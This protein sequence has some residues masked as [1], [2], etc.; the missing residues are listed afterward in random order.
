[1]SSEAEPDEPTGIPPVVAVVVTCDSGPWLEETLGA[2]GRQDYPDL[3]VLVLDAG[4]GEDPTPRVATALPTAFIR[5]LEVNAGFGPSANE[6]L[7]VVE[8]AS[9]YLFCHDD[10]APEPQ[11]V[12]LMVEEAY[13]S[14]A[15][16]VAPKLVA[17][18]DPMRLLAVG[19]HIDKA[20]VPEEQV[21][22]GELDQEQYDAVRDV[23]V[24]PG[25]C[26]LVRADLFTTLGGFDPEITMFGEDLDLCWR[27]QVLGARV[28]VAPA[29]RVRHLEAASAGKRHVLGM[30]AEPEAGRQLVDVV[31]PLQLRHRLRTVLK[32]YGRFHLARVLPQLAILALGETMF[33]V[34]ARRG[35]VAASIWSSWSW[36]WRW[37]RLRRLAAPRRAVQSQRA[38]PDREI[39]RLQVRGSA[40]VTAFLRGQLTAT[41]PGEA[42]AAASRDFADSVRRGERRLHLT[43]WSV[44]VVVLV[45]GSRHLLT[46]PLPDV[47]QFVP[48]PD[49]P[50][51]LLRLF[52]SGW[53]TTGLGS[54]SPAPLAFALLGGAG[55]A[56]FGAIGVVQK[57]V[58]LGCIPFG[59]VGIHRLARP[60]E[61]DRAPLVAVVAY[62]AIPLPYNALAGGRM[63]TLIAYAVTPWLLARLARAG[64]IPPFAGLLGAGSPRAR[65]AVPLGLLLAVAVA[66]APSVLGTFAVIVVGLIVGS[67]VAGG[68]R[69]AARAGVV[70]VGAILV[71]AALLF[72]WTLEFVLP[73]AE[74]EAFAGLLSPASDAPPLADLLRFKTGPM[75]A[76]PL[77][78]GVIV[79]AVVP[80]LLA[81]GDRLQ[82]SIRLWLIALIG[83]ILAWAL[84]R[85]WL[86]G[87][88]GHPDIFLAAA[89]PALSLAVANGVSAFE[90]ELHV[91]RFG[92][93]QLAA[94]V[95]GLA[96]VAGALPLLTEAI[97]GR[98]RA[99]VRSHADVL[100]WIPEQRAEGMF[101]VLWLGDPRV[102]PGGGWGI[103]EGLAYTTSRDGLADATMV[104]PGSSAGATEL[105]AD[106]VEVTERGETTSLGRLLAP[107]AI[108]YVVVPE[109]VAVDEGA[110]HRP[111]P[112]L[113]DRLAA[114]IDLKR[115]DTTDGIVVYENT[116]WIPGLAALS[117][118]SAAALERPLSATPSADLAGG[119]V[120]GRRNNVVSWSGRLPDNAVVHAAESASPRWRLAIEGDR[121]RRE[122]SFGFAN[123]YFGGD[124]GEAILRLHGS[125]GHYAALA[126]EAG[127]WLAA[128][129]AIRHWRRGE[130]GAQD[131]LGETAVAVE[132][133]GA[134]S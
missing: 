68:T 29:A 92:W 133:A 64:G 37:S 106:A 128:I 125:F 34:L 71:A 14:N 130:R 2:L 103:R 35:S 69:A 67:L 86:P 121:V 60:L 32:C 108:R 63:S 77:G 129:A 17:W 57:L 97:S 62:A 73:G 74:L 40:R 24:A 52:A 90:R 53:R 46:R 82:W 43:V 5:R 10:V 126:L 117:S 11:S 48:F 102:I 109:R 41:H 65:H 94:V 118:E 47:G 122:K 72:P 93:R 132:T 54:E 70:A 110:T 89:A 88:A 26:T 55:T 119:A 115:L 1:M 38:L 8:G 20:G 9:H 101:R 116:A 107:M 79:A 83:W 96:L 84:A 28:V 51:D 50:F 12:R 31:R 21:G 87:S 76:A 112:G 85:G 23:F 75:G 134:E 95:G 120:L 42:I 78:W 25:G 3:S 99:P 61:S 33:A 7:R 18:D 39:R 15:G 16:I 98:W 45:A 100:S 19:V 22:R 13:R 4:S 114:Q 36:N 127:L 81:R 30:T 58:I 56:L 49:S 80:L 105:I 91:Y 27:A 111:P 44:L 66:L 104:W 59:L 123:A 113:L 131:D 6:V 124:G